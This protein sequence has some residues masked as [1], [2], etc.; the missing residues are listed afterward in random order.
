MGA[1]WELRCEYVHTCVARGIVWHSTQCC[2]LTWC[3]LS[4]RNQRGCIVLVVVHVMHVPCMQQV[5]ACQLLAHSLT[6]RHCI[7][8][9]QV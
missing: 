7:V 1:G 2:R 9:W 6:H 8:S 5:A 4:L 3:R